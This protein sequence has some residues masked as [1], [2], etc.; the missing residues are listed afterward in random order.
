MS[1]WHAVAFDLDDTLY[2][3][4]SFVLGGFRAAAAWAQAHLGRPAEETSAELVSLFQDGVRGDT[5]DRWLASHGLGPD[6]VPELVRAY[7][8]HAPTLTPYPGIT[9]LLE[10]LQGSRRLGLLSDGDFAVQRRKLGA[11]G[12]SRYFDAIVFTDVWGRDGW[13]P[14]ARPFR[15]LLDG[16]GVDAAEAVYVADNPAKD[17]LGPRELGMSS[18]RVRFPDALHA[19]V[20]AP[21]EHHAA[22][23]CAD[24]VGELAEILGIALPG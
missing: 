11:L 5:F 3:E 10:S 7:R 18:I 21:T 6:A 17:F 22:D 24:S 4:W 2:P 16:L 9:G 23:L 15:E 8:E 1:R 12:I 14:A 20:P 19:G 13:K